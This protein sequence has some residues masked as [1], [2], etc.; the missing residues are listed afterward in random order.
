MFRKTSG[1]ILPKGIQNSNSFVY[2]HARVCVFVCVCVCVG[3]GG[4]VVF[5]V[6]G[7]CVVVVCW[8]WRVVV[9]VCVYVCVC[10]CVCVCVFVC[11]LVCVCVCVCV[12]GS[13]HYN[14]GSSTPVSFLS[15]P[16]PV[17][18]GNKTQAL[19]PVRLPELEENKTSVSRLLPN[20]EETLIR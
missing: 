6:V 12:C 19:C 17:A 8:V 1:R 9:V 5:C 20:T 7:G 3:V 14:F 15:L 18:L 16:A 13:S 4:C 11:V 2:V 10:V